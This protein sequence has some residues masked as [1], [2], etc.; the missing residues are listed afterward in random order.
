LSGFASA[1]FGGKATTGELRLRVTDPAGLGV[2]SAIELVSETNQ[3]RETFR[4]DEVG[5]L[6]AKR[7]PFGVYYL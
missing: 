2:Q 5:D 3:F 4:T 1:L 6:V 7:L